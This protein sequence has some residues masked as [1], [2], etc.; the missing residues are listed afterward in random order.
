MAPTARPR[1]STQP[2]NAGDATH[3][4][5]GVWVVG[6]TAANHVIVSGT[7]ETT[8]PAGSSG[9]TWSRWAQNHTIITTGHASRGQ[10][11]TV[12]V[13]ANDGLFNT[14]GCGEWRRVG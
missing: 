13:A 14:K 10:R 3:P 12:T 7:Y 2:T 9:C 8:V 6:T 1:P 5:D 4:G 11:A